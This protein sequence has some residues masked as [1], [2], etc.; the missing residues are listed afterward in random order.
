MSLR[1][2]LKIIHF[3]TYPENRLADALR[4]SSKITHIVHLVKNCIEPGRSL[5]SR[6]RGTP[7]I[8]RDVAP[9]LERPAEADFLNRDDVT[10][11]LERF[12]GRKA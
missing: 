11:L 10:A 2:S 12:F 6:S 7:H 1:F 9:F 4:F 8:H 3:F 5:I